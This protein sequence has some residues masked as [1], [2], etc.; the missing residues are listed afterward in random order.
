MQKVR[1]FLYFDGKSYDEVVDSF[2]DYKL[3]SA[4]FGYFKE[5]NR[6]DNLISTPGIFITGKIEK[7]HDS[8]AIIK[9]LRAKAGLD[10]KIGGCDLSIENNEDILEEIKSSELKGNYIGIRIMPPFDFKNI[11]NL[12]KELGS[13]IDAKGIYVRTVEPVDNNQK[14]GN[15]IGIRIMP[16]FDFK[17]I[18]DFAKKLGSIVDAK[19][20]YVKTVEPVDNNQKVC[21][22]LITNNDYS[23]YQSKIENKIK[24]NNYKLGKY[25]FIKLE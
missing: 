3:D 5:V 7:G 22:E 6:Y 20:I 15:Y 10:D 2:K 17:N 13:I 18:Y 16:P 8:S 24:S 25:T 11:C 9:K 14:K 1:G 12:A 21:I 23:V 4:N 19:S